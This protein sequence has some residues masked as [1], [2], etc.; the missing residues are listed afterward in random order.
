MNSFQNTLLRHLDADTI[1]RLS[2]RRV[3]FE[4]LHE[5]EFPG[6]TITHLFFVEEGVASMTAT[7]L[8]GSQVEVTM[9]GFESVVGVSALMGTRRSLNRVY[10]QIPGFGYSC[11][12]AAAQREFNLA[13]KFQDL[14]LRYVHAQLLQALQSVGCNAKHRM[15]ERLAR[16]LLI[17]ADRAQTSSLHLSQ[18]LLSSMLGSTRPSVTLA[19]G[20][21]RQEGLIDYVRGVV[22]ILDSP[23]L[24]KRSCEC[25][26]VIKQHLDNYAEFDT[27]FL[28]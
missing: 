6:K 19:A 8:D 3:E 11:T 13:G 24:E 14:T 21:L 12:I 16:W 15:E 4:L 7:F 20:I 22:N 2:L 25:Y 26:G 27:A 5:L 1:Q 18:E 23:R 17:C 10:T 9:F 28:R